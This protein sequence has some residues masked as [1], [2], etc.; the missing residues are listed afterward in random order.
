MRTLRRANVMALR[1]AYLMRQAFASRRW[2]RTPGRV[3][4]ARLLNGHEPRLRFLKQA[5]VEYEYRIGRDTHRGRT[6]RWTDY[7]DGDV[8]AERAVATYPRGQRIEV[9]YDPRDPRRSVL[10]TSV[11]W[12]AWLVTGLA[13]AFA[14]GFWWIVGRLVWR[15]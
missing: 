7:I 8:H 2:P 10:E 6:V 12:H 14:T 3:I 9:A 13:F 11:A 5:L 15:T 1:S 4:A